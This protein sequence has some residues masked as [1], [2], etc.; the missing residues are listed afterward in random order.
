[1]E[2]GPALLLA[3]SKQ[4]RAGAAACLAAGQKQAGGAGAQKPNGTHPACGDR[5][6]WQVQ[7]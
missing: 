6:A 3:A 4:S 7:E 2:R 5:A 1:M